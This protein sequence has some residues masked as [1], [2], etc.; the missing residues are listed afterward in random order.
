VLELLLAHLPLKT[1]VKLASDITGMPRNALYD[2]ALTIKQGG[3]DTHKS[4][5]T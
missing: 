3:E 5:S 1:A 2:L 4:Q